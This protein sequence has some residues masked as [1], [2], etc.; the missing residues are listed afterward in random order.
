MSLEVCLLMFERTVAPSSSGYKAVQEEK[1][2]QKVGCSIYIS[3][4]RVTK[5]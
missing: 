4:M 2:C 5:R 3:L 1:Q